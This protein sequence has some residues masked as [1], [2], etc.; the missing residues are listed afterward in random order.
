MIPH[1]RH[2]VRIGVEPSAKR[3]G[4]RAAR[5]LQ[6]P[7]GRAIVFERALDRFQALHEFGES[8]STLAIIVT[9]S[10]PHRSI[11]PQAPLVAIAVNGL[12]T[13]ISL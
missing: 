1:A 11:P 3:R 13:G 12:A 10:E 6:P 7:C 9:V 5:S 8:Y 4:P 2:R